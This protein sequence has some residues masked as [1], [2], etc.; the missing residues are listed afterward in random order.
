MIHFVSDPGVPGT[1]PSEG[2]G[3]MTG[4]TP[5]WKAMVSQSWDGLLGNKL[6]L[7]LT[8]R[9]ISAGV[10]NN[11]YIECQT[12]CPLPTAAH[13]TIFDNHMPGATY[14]DFGATYN[15]SKQMTAY[16]KIDNLADRD[17]VLV[18]QTNL[19]LALNPAIY[20]AIGRTYRAGLRMNF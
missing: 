1:T 19:S 17:P 11:E 4:A 15:I 16:F 10:F 14:I 6:S 3:N 5:K 9:W 2:A 12:N 8:E 7:T 13:P 20:D 18:P